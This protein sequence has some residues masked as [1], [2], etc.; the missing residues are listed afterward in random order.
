MAQATLSDVARPTKRWRLRPDPPQIPE[1]D[2]PALIGRLLALRGVESAAEAARFFATTAATQP[3]LPDI[4]KAVER[5]AQACRSG[6]TVAVF[7]DFDVD[8]ITSAALLYENLTELG[9]KPIPYLPHRE[10][11]GYGLSNAA[12]APS[13]STA[14]QRPQARARSPAV[15][16]RW[17]RGHVSA[18]DPSKDVI[19]VT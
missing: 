5:L 7:G 16:R 6:E 12:V 14:P 13:W 8:G 19:S 3:V 17:Q 1:G 2:W 11:E 10:S 15:S 4:D 9:A 18:T